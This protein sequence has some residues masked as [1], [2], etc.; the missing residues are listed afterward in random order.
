[1]VKIMFDITESS[2]SQDQSLAIQSKVLEYIREALVYDK[3]YVILSVVD[4]GQ[5]E[6]DIF[7]SNG[8]DIN[9][10]YEETREE[11]I[12]RILYTI[13]CAD[14]RRIRGD[15]GNVNHVIR[16]I[17]NFVVGA[18]GLNVLY[19]KYGVVDCSARFREGYDRMWHD[20]G[21]DGE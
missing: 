1:M 2:L 20:D 8:N 6:F 10:V 19:E 14:L 3:G 18:I 4:I 12:D 13:D 7:Y 21:N 9:A 16:Y 17:Y 15:S 11:T 5:L